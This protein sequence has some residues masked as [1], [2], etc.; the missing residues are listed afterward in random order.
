MVPLVLLLFLH[1]SDGQAPQPEQ[2]HISATEYR[3]GG[4]DGWSSLF[5]FNALKSGEDWSPRIAFY[6]DMGTT[7]AKSISYLQEDAQ[8]GKYDAILHVGDFAYDL[9]EDEGRNGDD[10][11]NEIQEIAAYVP[12]MTCPGNHE[13]YYNFS[14]YKNRFS[15]PGNTQGV[16]YSWNIGPAHIISYSTEVYFWLQFGI[17]QIVQQYD[18]LIRDLQEATLPENRSKRPWIITMAHKPMYCSNDDSDDCTRTNSIIRTGLTSKHLWPLEELFYKYGVD[19]MLEA[20]EHSYERLWP[21]YD[22]QICNGSLEEPYTNPCAPVHI[23]TGSAGCYSKHDPFKKE[24]P[25][26][27]AFRT[28]N[29]GFSQMTIFNKTHIGIQQ[30][31]VDLGGKVVDEIMLIKDVHG[32]EAWVRKDVKN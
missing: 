16:F 14:H 30:V 25:Y 26:W 15:M 5:A 28:E 10:F 18:W 11:M 7:N 3:C 29:Y 20:H 4:Y 9:F 2:I 17:E 21:I 13:R 1:C 31:D 24:K 22:M 27:T 8:N 6:G 12:Y 19:M 23:V 32:P